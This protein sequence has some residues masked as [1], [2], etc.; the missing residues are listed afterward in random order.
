MTKKVWLTFDDG[1]NGLKTPTVLDVLKNNG[2]TATFFMIGNVAVPNLGTA[3]KVAAAGHFV[4]NHSNTH[5]VVKGL[6]KVA[7]KKEIVDA[8]ATLSGLATYMKWFCPPEGKYDANVSAVVNELNFKIVLWNVDTADWDSQDPAIRI[9][10]GIA[11]IKAKGDQ[12]VVINHDIYESTANHLQEF[13]DQIK[14]IGGVTFGS[15]GDMP[16]MQ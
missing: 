15:P 9:P 12:C 10:K 13:I 7:I 11:G 5:T 3:K 14:Q 4:G 1:P 16:L 8:D 6:S 2:I